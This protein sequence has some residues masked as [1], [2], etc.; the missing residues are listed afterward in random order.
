M[1]VG[2]AY[3]HTCT[4]KVLTPPHPLPVRPVTPPSFDGQSVKSSG[5]NTQIGQQ[6][7]LHAPPT[8]GS[9]SPSSPSSPHHVTR[10]PS[11]TIS[12]SSRISP[13]P[14]PTPTETSPGG[15]GVCGFFRGR[16]CGWG[17][18]SLNNKGIDA[19]LLEC[20]L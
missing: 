2:V 14:L 5:G 17:Y 1:E 7:S 9:A 11:P 20:Y 4:K 16:V 6:A 10:H 3:L 15:L 8:C 13:T 12:T 19:K 18:M